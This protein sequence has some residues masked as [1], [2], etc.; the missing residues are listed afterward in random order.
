[1]EI[2]RRAPQIGEQR[3]VFGALGLSAEDLTA[4]RESGAIRPG[5]G[6]SLTSMISSA[7]RPGLL[8]DLV[9]GGRVRGLDKAVDAAGVLVEPV[10]EVVDAVLALHLQVATVRAGDGLGRRPSTLP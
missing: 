5:L 9:G 2:R 7:S 10:L 3:G 1:M 4:L 8:V 6:P